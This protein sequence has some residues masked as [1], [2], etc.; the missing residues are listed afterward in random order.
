MKNVK[1]TFLAL[2]TAGA[3][4]AQSLDIDFGS[5]FDSSS[6]DPILFADASGN[7]FTN[8][9]ITVGYFGDIASQSDFSGYLGDFTQIG[10]ATSFSATPG[11]QPASASTTLDVSGESPFVF[12]LGGIS[13]FANASTATSYSIFGDSGWGTL[14][15]GAVPPAVANL[16]TLTPDNIVVGSFTASGDGGTLSAVSTVAVPEP[17]AYA[18]LGG[19][20]ALTCVMLRRRA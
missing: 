15:A 18:L 3:L 11:Y 12:V 8:A 10:S 6:F 13:D 5:T 1:I 19:L 14:P 17:S 2:L 9:V 7:P 20:L 4:N 16:L